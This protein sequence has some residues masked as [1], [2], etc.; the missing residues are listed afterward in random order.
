MPERKRRLPPLSLLTGFEAAARHLS[1]TR[2]A[3][4][5]ALT[6]SAVSKQVKALEA[7]FG[8]ALFERRSRAL[9]LTAEGHRL[10]RAVSELVDQLDRAADRL[11]VRQAPLQVSVATSSGFAALWLIPRLR[12][13]TTMHPGIDVRISTSAEI[14]NLEQ[15]RLD[16]ALRFCPSSGAPRG[17]IKLFTHATLPVCAPALLED[18]RAPLRTPED[19]KNHVLLHANISAE[20]KA[21]VDWD[22][23]LEAAR[24]PNLRPKGSLHFNQ[25]EQTIQAALQGQGVALGIDTLVTD[26]MREK[27]LVAPFPNSIAESRNCYVVRALPSL[28]KPEVDAFIGWLRSEAG[29]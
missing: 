26:L 27:L 18:A 12:R 25:Y 15:C 3:E 28:S 1:F 19:L 22:A 6:Q 7:H 11:R 9:L 4:E 10:Y 24:L 5:L 17:A 20:R 2:A 21:Y 8:H 13:F 14:V 29:R 16:L 23:W